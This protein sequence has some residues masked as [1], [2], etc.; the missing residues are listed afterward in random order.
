MANPLTFYDLPLK[1]RDLVYDYLDL[2]GN[3]INLNYTHLCAYP[4]NEYPNDTADWV[5][6]PCVITRCEDYR[7]LEEYWEWS[8][9]PCDASLRNEN[10]TYDGSFKGEF[11]D[12]VLEDSWGS[13]AEVPDLFRTI[14]GRNNFRI[15]RGSPGGFAPFFQLP[16]DALR[17]LGT[18]TV[19]LDGEPQSTI[20]L[21]GDWARL[22]ELAPLKPHSRYGKIAMKEWER[23]VQRLTECVQPKQLTLY[24]IVN[25][26]DLKTAEAVLK[27]LDQ[28][29][30]L[31]DCGIWL[32][33]KSIPEVSTLI[34]TTI[35]RLTTSSLEYQRKPFRY[36]DL[37]LELRSRILEY[38][39]LVSHADL[40]WKPSLSSIGCIPDPKCSCQKNTDHH[41]FEEDQHMED[42]KRE[43]LE[44]AAIKKHLNVWDDC[45]WPLKHCCNNNEYRTKKC[46]RTQANFCECIFYCNHCAG[47]SSAISKS[48]M[49][50]HPLFLVSH[51]VREDATPV[52][53]QRNRFV[54][55]PPG[56]IP[57]RLVAEWTRYMQLYSITIPMRRVE[58]SLFLSSLARNVFHHIRY[59]EWV[60]PQFVN[61]K[62]ATRSAYLDYLDTIDMMAHAMHLPLLTLV[63]NLRA[64]EQP[65]H[66]Q[67][68]FWPQRLH[69]DEV[70]Y[71]T[72]LD[73]LCRLKGL[74]D[75]FVYLRRF[76][77]KGRN[78]YDTR[79]YNV[80][81]R[82]ELKFEKAI[83]GPEYDSA[84][85]GKPWFERFE[86][87]KRGWDEIDDESPSFGEYGDY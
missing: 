85:R 58:L 55:S 47:S 36:L 62:T 70:M 68:G 87:R 27:P 67:H 69:G 16:T 12:E 83:M 17:K 49:G 1:A 33:Y 7:T 32:N 82:D 50:T 45:G 24:L 39:D 84:K 72:I 56:I 6:E 22:K 3:T 46:K 42:C 86:R 52:F 44:P 57:M 30:M 18:L 37:P 23:L 28:L 65:W 54:V 9:D 10:Y 21:N 8:R 38:S 29:P 43:Y 13:M 79:S 2:T 77:R 48:M 4:Q 63:L 61:Y 26:P 34:Q 64:I 51:Q 59:L 15:C 35:K 19:R 66:P 11:F 80:F 40:E 78:V 41:R 25:V 71:K 74:K 81:D 76:P 60:L 20:K 73:P 5:E 53:F 31:K 14:Y 75:C